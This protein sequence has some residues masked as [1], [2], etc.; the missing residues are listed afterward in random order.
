MNVEGTVYLLHF[1]R[2]YRGRSQHY[3]GFTRNLTQRLENHRRG[4]A[5]A[6]T[7]LAFDRGIGF[8]LARTWD[9]TPKLERAI[10]SQGVVKCCPICPPALGR[11]SSPS[12]R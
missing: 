3:L 7:K 12:D 4:T 8:I 6:T 11:E 9:G 1:E 2:P 5:C 10:K